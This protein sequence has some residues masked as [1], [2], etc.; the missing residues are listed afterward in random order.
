MTLEEKVG[1]L[2]QYSAGTPTGP[3][4]GRSGYGEMIEKGQIG[5]LFN[6]TGAEKVNAMQRIAVEKSRLHIPILF[7]LDVIH[8]YRTTFPI[9]LAMSATWDT[10][11][12]ERPHELPR[13]NPLPREFA[14]HFLP[15]LTLRAT[16]V[17]AASPRA[18]EKIPSSA[19]LLRGPM[20]ADIRAI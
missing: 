4:T 15:W 3:G 7:G 14:G 12:I 9:P 6:L 10:A 16:R 19:L 17:G 18:Q 2:N 8:G 20:C 11:M 1:Q 13:V 5:S